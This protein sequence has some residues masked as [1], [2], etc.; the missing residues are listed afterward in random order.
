MSTI[1]PRASPVTFDPGQEVLRRDRL[2]ANSNSNSSLSRPSGPDRSLESARELA[3]LA[4]RRAAIRV[5]ADA[6]L[7]SQGLGASA[8]EITFGTSERAETETHDETRDARDRKEERVE[9]LMRIDEVHALI[10]HLAGEPAFQSI[11]QRAERFAM[12]WARGSRETALEELDRGGFAPAERRVLME[13]ALRKLPP[14]ADTNGLDVRMS[15]LE[16]DAESAVR[17]LMRTSL[18]AGSSASAKAAVAPDS[19]LLAASH[20]PPTQKLINDAA[21]SLGRDGLDQ[22]EALALSRGRIDPRL[23]RGAEVF[24]SLS[25]LRMVQQVRQVEQFGI[26]LRKKSGAPGADNLEDVRKTTRWLLDVMQAPAPQGVLAK[27]GLVMNVK[28]DALRRARREMLGELPKLPDAVWLNANTKHL[29][30]TDLKQ[31]NTDQLTEQ[32]LLNRQ[33]LTR[34]I[35]RVISVA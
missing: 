5:A 30:K 4:E 12:L 2:F 14:G 3:Q 1:T 8:E 35:R 26:G 11:R 18:V 32:G 25:L 33:G 24:L 31:A 34:D 19:A 15:E 29:V 6:A 13:M 9:A 7:N 22:L 28:G 23:S 10:R 20:S 27:M 21:I 17:Q 16:S